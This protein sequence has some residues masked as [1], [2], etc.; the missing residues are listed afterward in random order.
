MNYNIQ[1]TAFKNNKDFYEDM[2][3][4]VIKF[5]KKHKIKY[6][7]KAGTQKKYDK[8]TEKIFKEN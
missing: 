2:A 4:K 7:I 6:H 5:C 3:K 8:S 1:S